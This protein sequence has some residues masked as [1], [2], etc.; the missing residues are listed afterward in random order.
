MARVRQLAYADVKGP[1]RTTRNS[2]VTSRPYAIALQTGETNMSRRKF[3]TLTTEQ[4]IEDACEYMDR[5]E[6]D[7]LQ[8]LGDESAESDDD[9]RALVLQARAGLFDEGW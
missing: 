8:E 9:E 5:R 4:D 2:R 6:R 3:I 1:R 7:A